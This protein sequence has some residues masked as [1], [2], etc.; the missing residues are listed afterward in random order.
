[1]T[2]TFTLTG[3]GRRK[4]QVTKNT[5]GAVTG[6]LERFYADDSDNPAWT[7]S[8]ADGAGPAAAVVTRYAESIAG[9]LGAQIDSTGGLELTLANPRGDAVTSVEI[10]A[11]QG[12]ATPATAITAWSDY[13]EYGAPTEPASAATVA[14]P[15]GYAFLGGKQRSTTEAT[16]GLT[17][18]GDRLYNQ[19][20]GLF[21]SLD[22]EPGGNENAYTYPNDPINAY[23]LDGH[24]GW[25]RSWGKARS[26]V[27]RS[28]AWTGRAARSVTDSKWGKRIH[29]ACG[30]AWG[31]AGKACSTVYGI[32]YARQGRWSEAGS[33]AVGFVVG[34]G[35]SRRAARAFGKV[36]FDARY[37]NRKQVRRYR[38]VFHY[39]SQLHGVAAQNLWSGAFSKWRSRRRHR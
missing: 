18:M 31:L 8:D 7:V 37:Y 21:T 5:A 22:P 14:G 10:P 26:W 24:R 11:G 25:S 20:R 3:G 13:S 19:T 23:D 32:A 17:L 39:S 9:D 27:K 1:M 36:R 4:T 33:E 29:S 12:E 6:T 15:A 2:T 30:F 35:V 38:R 16:A 34:S 28:W